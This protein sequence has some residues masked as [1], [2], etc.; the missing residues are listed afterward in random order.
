[1]MCS[2]SDSQSLRSHLGKR[3]H[4]RLEGDSISLRRQCRGYG[5]RGYLRLGDICDYW[6][7]NCFSWTDDLSLCTQCDGRI[8]CYVRHDC[9]LNGRTPKEE[10]LL[11]HIKRTFNTLPFCRRWLDRPDGGSFAVNGRNGRQEKCFDTLQELVN[12]EIVEVGV[13]I[14]C[15]VRIILLCVM[16]KEATLHSGNI[17]F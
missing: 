7:R 13:Y 9:S 3:V 11:K 15:H 17:P 4:S 2:R 10:A 8:P 1:M 14:S 16:L 5:R 6:K 12:K